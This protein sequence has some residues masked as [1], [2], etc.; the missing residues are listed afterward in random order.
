[1]PPPNITKE[2]RKAI[3]ELKKD[4]TR[5][6]LT[7]DK[8]VSL[9]VMNTEDYIRKAEDL[10]NQTTYKS[11]P[12]DPTTTYKNKLITLLKTI[13]AEGGI[14]ETVYR[15][16]YP[17]GAGFPKF[18]GLAKIHKEGI[19]LRP[20]VSSIGEVTYETSKEL[21]MILKPLVGR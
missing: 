3:T 17:T 5:M 9:V 21:A 15:R 12:T 6:I 10:L 13:K 4:S 2:E 18:Y 14:N 19:Q 1:M 20:I 8:G 7:A 11:I 16:L